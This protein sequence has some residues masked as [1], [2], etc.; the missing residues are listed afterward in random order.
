MFE[1]QIELA[2]PEVVSSSLEKRVQ[3]L[4]KKN[5][6]YVEETTYTIKNRFISNGQL[7]SRKKALTRNEYQSLLLQLK[8]G[9]RTVHKN[10]LVIEEFPHKNPTILIDC[11]VKVDGMPVLAIFKKPSF[12]F[13]YELPEYLD[14][15]REVTDEP[16]YSRRIMGKRS[17]YM[18]P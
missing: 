15:V 14:I 8:K 16:Q 3:K 13:D 7:I 17:Y 9:T 5:D 11:Y 18:D 12:D 4:K 1:T 6:K 10:R 2:D